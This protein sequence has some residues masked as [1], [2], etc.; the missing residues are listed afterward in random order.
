MPVSFPG[1]WLLGLKSLKNSS[2]KK[3]IHLKPSCLLQ[4]NIFSSSVGK[5]PLAGQ[6]NRGSKKRSNS[7]LP[8]GQHKEGLGVGV[9]PTFSSGWG[10]GYSLAYLQVGAEAL[11]EASSWGPHG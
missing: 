7:V 8:N 6:G 2:F 9:Q 10:L 4:A 1:C 11:Q 5:S 3:H